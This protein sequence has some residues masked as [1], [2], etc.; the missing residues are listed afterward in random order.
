[1]DTTPVA[2]ELEQQKPGLVFDAD[3]I[4]LVGKFTDEI[5]AYRAR[6]SWIDVTKNYFL[7]ESKRDFEMTI[8]YSEDGLY[9]VSCAFHSACGRYAFWRLVNRQAP[10]AEAKLYTPNML[11]TKSARFLL[12]SLWPSSDSGPWLYSGKGDTQILGAKSKESFLNRI[13]RFFR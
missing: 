4:A 8:R 13:G 9:V 7:L 6:R 1:L 3:N 2:T 11:N 10:E 12:G 5:S